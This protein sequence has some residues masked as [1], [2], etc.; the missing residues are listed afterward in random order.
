M[1]KPARQRKKIATNGVVGVVA[2]FVQSGSDQVQVCRGTYADDVP[3]ARF[4]FNVLFVEHN[5]D[6]PSHRHQYTE[7]VIVLDGNATH[8]SDRGTHD[9]IKGDVVVITDGQRHGFK[10]AKK[11]QLC[12]V[13]FD[14]A[15]VLDDDLDL[16]QMAGF[17]SLFDLDTRHPSSTRAPQR[18]HLE[19][20]DLIRCVAL[21]RHLE[22][23]LQG[24]EE[25]KKTV[26]RGMFQ[27]LVTLLSRRYSNQQAD[28]QTP[29]ARLSRVVAY[30]RTHLRQDLPI[31]ELA[32]MAGLSPSQ[33]QRTFNR[34]YGVTPISFIT[35]LRIDEAR[36]LLMDHSLTIAAVAEAAGFATQAFFA[37]RFRLVT[38]LS[39][40]AYRHALGELPKTLA[41]DAG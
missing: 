24:G 34:V 6:F 21:A 22:S 40:S 27:V 33:F 36:R 1:P 18:L 2:Q 17:H 20:A 41:A 30:M 9:L 7:L 38:G 13:Q 31:T 11:L 26:I 14:Q 3:D 39:P 29:V 25:G 32:A 35:R 10:D 28:S 23:E 37:T 16:R 15:Q 5:G 8:I 19:T 4:R 12:N